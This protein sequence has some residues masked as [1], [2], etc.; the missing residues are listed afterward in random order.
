MNIE[1]AEKDIIQNITDFSIV[2][3][4]IISCHDFRAENGEG[5]FYRSRD[6]VTKTLKK[7]GFT[8]RSFNY[9]TNWA[10]DWIY[11]EQ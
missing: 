10:D 3:R 2:K 5:D 8:I 7:N 1:G 4:F 6:V 11:A 9:S